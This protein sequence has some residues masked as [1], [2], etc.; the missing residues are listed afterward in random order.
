MIQHLNPYNN[1][2]PAQQILQ[3]NGK[4]SIDALRMMPNSSVL[5]ADST[6]PIVWKCVSDGLGN[7]CA[8]AFDISPHKSQ[9]QAEK[10]SLIALVQ[11]IDERLK[12]LENEQSVVTGHTEPDDAEFITSK[13]NVTGRKKSTGIV[14]ADDAE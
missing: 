11:S 10:D 3:A 6:A 12:R 1:V 14:T 8:E 9:E 13:K 2:L 5:I 7:V 4:Q